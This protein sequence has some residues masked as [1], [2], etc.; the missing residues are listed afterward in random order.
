LIG[1]DR[2]PKALELAG[3]RLQA[4]AEELGDAMPKVTLIGEAFSKAAE[5]VEA[6]KS[7][8]IAG[9]LWRQQHAAR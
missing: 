5:H 6:R 2:D 4:L 7:R 9:R 8:W 3:Q 1:F